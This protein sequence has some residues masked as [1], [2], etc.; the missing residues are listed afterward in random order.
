[1]KVT[2][3]VNVSVVTRRHSGIEYYGAIVR[4]DFDHLVGRDLECIGF[5]LTS[6]NFEAATDDL[7]EKESIR[8]VLGMT[9]AVHPAIAKAMVEAFG[10]LDALDWMPW[11]AF[12]AVA[13][14]YEDDRPEPVDEDEEIK[15]G[16]GLLGFVVIPEVKA[17][18]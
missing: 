9:G 7:G 17:P 18:S 6:D 12:D 5:E 15:I 16:E 8:A 3:T 1:M 10:D 14:E 13:F 11:K 4:V 2:G